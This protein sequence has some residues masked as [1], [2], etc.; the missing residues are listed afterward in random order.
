[1]ART[2]TRR[3]PPPAATPAGGGCPALTG[4]TEE[5]R[6]LLELF[7]GTTG[8]LVEI[9]GEPGIGKTRL[10]REAAT[11]TSAVVLWGGATE[12]ESQLAFAVFRTAFED[13]LPGVDPARL[14]G[15]DPAQLTL[16][17][18]IFPSLPGS[19]DAGTEPPADRFRLH[20]AVRALLECVAVDGPLLLVLD[21]LHWAD[22]GTLELVQHLLRH[23]PQAA[24]TIAVAYRPRQA[25]ARLRAAI[26][27]AVDVGTAT[28]IEL[29]PLRF[30]EVSPLLPGF[31][32]PA[33]KQLY[34]QSEGNPLYLEALSRRATN[35]L[36]ATD[37]S[38]PVQLVLGSEI[39]G[40]D[41]VPLLV[42]RAAAIVGDVFEPAV[43]AEVAQVSPGVV[44]DALDCLAARDLVR[45]AGAGDRH[46]F[47]HP[48][49]RHAAY[50]GTGAGWRIAAHG[51]AAAALSSRG[52]PAADQAHHV[53]QSG[54][55]DQAAIDIL[56]EAADTALYT[57]PAVAAHWF[58]ATLR[59]LPASACRHAVLDRLARALG[60]SGHLVESREVMHELLTSLPRSSERRAHAACFCAMIERLLGRYAEAN[61]MLLAEL[62]DLAD[63]EGATAIIIKTGLAF[64]YMLRGDFTA[65]RDWTDEAVSTAR[66]LG[67]PL[68]LG[69]ALTVHALGI[70]MGLRTAS[71][72]GTREVVLACLAEAGAIADRLTDP[73]LVEHID[74]YA[75][76]GSAEFMVEH[77]PA[78][79][80]HLSRILRVARASGR[81]HLQTNVALGLG[82]LCGR[83]G[84][85]RQA[86]AHFDDARD[87]A[88]LT[89]STEQ[90]SLSQACRSWIMAWM[91]DIEGALSTADAAAEIAGSLPGYFSV[92]TRYRQAYVRYYAGD[93]EACT[94]LLLAGCGGPDLTLLDPLS[95]LNGYSILTACAVDLGLGEE[96]L[97][98]AERAMAGLATA[99]SSNNI[100]VANMAM[101]TALSDR[102]PV[103]ALA[104]AE[105]AVAAF[106]RTGDLTFLGCAHLAASRSLG[107]D[108]VAARARIGRARELFE[109]AEALLFLRFAD[110]AQR[111]LN[112]RQ[113]RNGA[114]AG[115]TRRE[116]E[117]ADLVAAGLTNRAIAEQLFLS[118]RTVESHVA[119]VLAKLEVSTRSAIVHALSRESA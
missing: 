110:K 44:L 46:Q 70:M 57:A 16:L 4:R 59:L 56:V 12:Y 112:A 68:L 38:E 14:D 111:R 65:E 94:R 15:L 30:D 13:F 26:R 6:R 116:R 85:M 20:R 88:L 77:Y 109:K 32:E 19:G 72:S 108:I 66:A 76:L 67:D 114:F 73:E 23:P 33:R 82:S 83:T 42:A 34:E 63:T 37:P 101:S 75:V 64:G 71:G 36:A 27:A 10:L 24:L 81:V 61:A 104:H 43:V 92:T 35:G 90:L 102:D 9:V 41:P 3:Q 69:S 5:F 51:R 119:K 60:M 115:L 49:V 74:A 17:R 97:S 98:W 52:A 58:R 107:D 117:I 103:T 28:A 8:H 95:R 47:R 93:S 78:A 55:S 50:Q 25:P 45:P 84:R 89:G 106:T 21:D 53:E 118:A 7:S 62:D 96:A 105:T 11:A 91:G 87:S 22:D 29:R 48:L 1:M 40:L 86:L 39:A 80:R 79:E 2:R 31:D 100:G 18:S 113:S 99:P 54:R